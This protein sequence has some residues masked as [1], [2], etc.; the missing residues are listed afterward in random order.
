MSGWCPS[1]SIDGST[2]VTI[3][4]SND[5]K[6]TDIVSSKTSQLNIAYSLPEGEQSVLLYINSERLP[7]VRAVH[8][9]LEREAGEVRD[10]DLQPVYVNAIKD[11]R[12][13]SF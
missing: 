11:I 1:I 4:L 7:G 5:N 6:N 12:L 8:N 3:I 9:P 10:Q 2:A 13:F